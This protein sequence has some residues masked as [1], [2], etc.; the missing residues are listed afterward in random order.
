MSELLV[1]DDVTVEVRRRAVPA[2]VGTV[3]TVGT[4]V[5]TVT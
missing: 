5:R 2:G 4:V 3:G 1:L